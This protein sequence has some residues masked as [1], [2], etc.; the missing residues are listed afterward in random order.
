MNQRKG[1]LA[2]MQLPEIVW[3]TAFCKSVAKLNGLAVGHI[4]LRGRPDMTDCMEVALYRAS[5]QPNLP[6]DSNF[7][8]VQY[9][10]SEETADRRFRKMAAAALAKGTPCA[11]VTAVKGQL[12]AIVPY[13]R[14]SAIRN[15]D[16]KAGWSEAVS[17]RVNGW[18]LVS[19]ESH[20]VALVKGNS[21][22]FFAPKDADFENPAPLSEGQLDAALLTAREWARS[23]QVVHAF[24]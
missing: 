20:R 8:D 7:T 16:A 10:S 14:P 19:R 1:E 2:E 17:E 4:K 24:A 11:L 18:G 13:V 3:E 15:K 5:S 21:L 12:P 6:L 9:V 23:N 22:V